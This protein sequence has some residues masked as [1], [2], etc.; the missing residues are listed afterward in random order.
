MPLKP[1]MLN[2][3]NA[4][5]KFLST[6]REILIQ[7]TKTKLDEKNFGITSRA[8]IKS[9]MEEMGPKVTVQQIME[10]CLPILMDKIPKDIR[11]FIVT[12]IKKL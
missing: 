4:L 11:S 10:V 8:L 3:S 6:R 7:Q 12:E 2:D 5:D 9:K 1:G